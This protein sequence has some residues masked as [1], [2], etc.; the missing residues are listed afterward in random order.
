MGLFDRIFSKKSEADLKAERTFQTFECYRPVFTSWSG[1]IYESELVRAAVDAKARHISKLKFEMRGTAKPGLKSLVSYNPN[2]FQTWSQ[3][4][5]RLSVILDINNTA[6]IVPVMNRFMEMTGYYPLLPSRCEIVESEGVAYLRYRFDSGRAAAIELDRCALLVKH[7]YSRDFFGE[8]NGVLA[9]T[10]G[11]MHLQNEGIKEAIKNGA[12]F[13]FMATLTN[14]RSP[15]D[16]AEERKAFTDANF[17]TGNDGFLLF[18]NTYSNVQQIKSQPFTIDAEQT[19]QIK[20]NVFNYFGVNEAILQNTALGDDLD[21]FYEG[22]IEPFA[23]QTSEAMTNMTFSLNERRFGNQIILLANRLQ[24]MKTSDKI[25][26]VKELAD[27]G[28]I[29][30]NEAREVLNYAPLEG[31]EGNKRPARG[32]YYFVDAN[33]NATTK[34]GQKDGSEE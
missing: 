22:A 1:K 34:E 16:L 13:R 6:F 7:Q 12:R 18:P 4:L 29:T 21:A 5:Y 23:I 14:F 28:L 9:P 19:A 27:R 26:Y 32:E 11:L 3:F 20:T 10:M 33:G 31:D 24:Y 8:S 17:A 2:S 25:A 30:I 15:K